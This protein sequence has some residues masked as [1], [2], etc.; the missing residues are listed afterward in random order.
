MDYDRQPGGIDLHI[1][2]TASDGTF[3]PDQIL[4]MAENAGLSAISIT[5]HDTIEGLRQI[6]DPKPAGLRL[7]SGVEISA[8]APAGYPL[9]GSLH[10]LGYGFDP[11]NAGLNRTLG[12]LQTARTGRN[13][14]ILLKLRSIG[15]ELPAASVARAAGGGQVGRPH[16]AQAMV[17][18]GFAASIDDAFDRFLGAGGPAYVDK[19]RIPCAEAVRTIRE[20]GGIAVLAHPFLVKQLGDEGLESLVADLV[21]MGLG[22][23]EIYYPGHGPQQ[24]DIG[25]SL[26]ARFGLLVTGG[27]DFHGDLTPAVRLGTGTGNQFVPFSL[28]ERLVAALPAG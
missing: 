3:S 6:R 19:Y 8:A 27:T 24:I 7:L 9:R 2:S 1:H 11:G 20:A 16:I 10:I 12:Q 26:A 14:K 25:L 28:Y 4:Q 15:I 17:R 5:D 23:I 21:S 18:H 13:P 22:G